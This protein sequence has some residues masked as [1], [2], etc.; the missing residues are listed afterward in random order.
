MPEMSWEDAIVRV[1]Q[2]NLDV[3]MTNGDVA[4]VIMD[5]GF[6]TSV[7]KTPQNTIGSRMSALMERYGIERLNRGIYIL[8]SS[9]D[10][11]CAAPIEET[12][13]PPDDATAPSTIGIEAYGVHWERNKVHWQSGRILGYAIDPRETID[14]ANQQG[15]YVLYDWNSV[16]YVGQTIARTNGLFQRLQEAHTKREDW[17]DRWERF[18]WFGIR[19]VNEVG[20]L[21]D[22]PINA[23]LRAVAD[24]LESVLIETLRPAFNR[25]LRG[26][27]MGTLYRQAIDPYLSVTR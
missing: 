5:K 19:P 15:V 3:E 21:T 4:Q 24:L 25:Q 9:G 1:Y 16:V 8:R 6:R 17:G 11:T 7:G 13:D 23:D 22:A 27:N 2:E 12:G 14:F 18:S 20:E 10:E 26:N